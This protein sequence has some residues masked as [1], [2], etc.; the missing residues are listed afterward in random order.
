MKVKQVMFDTSM[1]TVIMD[2]ND[3]LIKLLKKE[4]CGFE[5][6]DGKISYVFDKNYTEECI[7]T[8]VTNKRGVIQYESH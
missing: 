7:I 4:D 1:I 8:D 3:S 2:D 5:E 6:I